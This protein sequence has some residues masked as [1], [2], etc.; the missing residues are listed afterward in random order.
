MRVR[1][2]DEVE[3]AHPVALHVV[4]EDA[5]PLDEPAIL[6]P[7]DV[8]PD[9][10]FLEGGRALGL[11]GGHACPPVPAARTASTMFQYPVQRQMFPCSATLT[12]SSVGLG[13]CSSSA[14]AL[15]SMPGVQ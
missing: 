10:A 15:I 5:L 6:F 13:F 2:A 11:D 12:S 8:L 3:V 9:E 7:R 14:V 4:E 1:R